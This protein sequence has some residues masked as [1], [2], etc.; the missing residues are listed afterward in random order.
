MPKGH[1]FLLAVEAIGPPPK[2]GAG[3]GNVELQA[4]PIRKFLQAKASLGVTHGE[5]CQSH[6]AGRLLVFDDA[7]RG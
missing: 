3:N 4:T 2:F 6:D 5:V 7:N 1:Q